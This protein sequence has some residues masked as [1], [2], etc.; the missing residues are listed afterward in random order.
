MF[1]ILKSK[2]FKTTWKIKLLIGI[3]LISTFY[4]IRDLVERTEEEGSATITGIVIATDEEKNEDTSNASNSKS[5]VL[6]S[7]SGAS[8]VWKMNLVFFLITCWI[9]MVL[10]GWGSIQAGGDLANPDV[11]NVSMW[12][13]AVSQ[14]VMYS[15]YLW[16]LLA[17]SI[18]PNRDFT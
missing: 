12:M 7:S 14:W 15:L 16:S 5:A 6:E 13:V 18:L 3:L 1:L 4:T 8:N 2:L 10:T 9:S 11:H 17:P